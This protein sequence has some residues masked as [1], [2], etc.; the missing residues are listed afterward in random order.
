M[1]LTEGTEL[2]NLHSVRSSGFQE[3]SQESL[4]SRR[5]LQRQGEQ[6]QVPL[7]QAD[8]GRQ[9]WMF[10]LG[11]FFI[12]GLTWGTSILEVISFT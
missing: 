10:L 4:H 5:G 7:A 8:G 9:A 6:E 2:P 1:A 12:E 3:G 11:S